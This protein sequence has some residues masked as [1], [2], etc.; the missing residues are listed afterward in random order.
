MDGQRYLEQ[1]A[2]VAAQL[3][4]G[5]GYTQTTLNDNPNW[6]DHAMGYSAFDVCPFS[7]NYKTGTNLFFWNPSTVHRRK[8]RR[9]SRILPAHGQSPTEL[10]VHGPHPRHQRRAK[11]RSNHR[12]TNEQ[13]KYRRKRNHTLESQQE[14]RAFCRLVRFPSHLIPERYR[15]FG[16]D[17][18]RAS[19]CSCSCES[20][21]FES[22]H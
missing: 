6:K 3:L 11:R 10:L 4:S 21:S 18:T 12:C 9:T 14:S 2:V 13:H 20:T 5:Q 1:S 22:I 8:T 16:Y 15:A 19:E 7:T 17:T